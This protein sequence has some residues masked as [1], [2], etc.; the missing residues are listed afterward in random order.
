[1]QR[2]LQIHPNP[3]QYLAW[4]A[5][6]DPEIAE[7]HYGGGAGGGKTWLGCESRLARAYSH[8]GYNSF[9]G[10]NK[11]TRL[12]ATCFVSF[13]NVCTFHEI[14]SDEWHLIGKY[15]YIEFTIGSRLDLLDL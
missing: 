2:K 15:N 10:R 13:T 12:V 3:K 8:P 14:P 11:L 7:I 4:Q 5:L 6:N 9:I 1:M